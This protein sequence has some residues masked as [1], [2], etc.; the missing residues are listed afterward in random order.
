MKTL[1]ITGVLLFL[2][3][4]VGIKAQS[5]SQDADFIKSC[6]IE[7]RIFKP[8]M[9]FGFL[10]DCTK[11]T[12]NSKLFH[13]DSIPA[14]ITKRYYDDN[15]IPSKQL[16]DLTLTVT[17]IENLPYRTKRPLT[18]IIA[19]GSDGNRYRY[20]ISSSSDT[21]NPSASS[22]W[23]LYL[24][25]EL[26]MFSKLIGQTIYG[27]RNLWSDRAE[28]GEFITVWG[29]KYSPLKVTGLIPGR[30]TFSGAFYIRFKTQG[31]D[32]EYYRYCENSEEFFNSIFTFCDPKDSFK[33]INNKDWEAIQ[34]GIPKAGMKKE[35]L[36]L[37]LGKPDKISTYSTNKEDMELW[38]YRNVMG[39]SYQI[40][41]KKDKVDSISSSE[42]N[43]RY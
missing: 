17:G 24:V 11:E 29:T 8:G 3:F 18:F 28:N 38:Y 1:I 16:N 9:K 7:S 36:E 19:D 32:K 40:L 5:C 21:L 4:P 30:G 43:S 34:N 23:C 39:K 37:T 2:L 42:Y 12:G 15:G 25:E 41:F 6:V 33:N 26:E 35:I 13:Y 20:F 27:K 10:E 22:E 31:T 14:E